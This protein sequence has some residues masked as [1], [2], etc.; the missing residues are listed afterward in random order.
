MERLYQM[1]VIPDVLP[2]FRPTVDLHV[3]ARAL[4]K[5]FH[6][7]GKVSVHVEPGAFLK[8]GQVRVP[9]ALTILY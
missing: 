4:P 1:K 3:T 6:E 2:D 7:T 9:Y 8:P 5:Q